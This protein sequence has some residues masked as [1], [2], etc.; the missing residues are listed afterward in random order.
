MRMWV[1][2]TQPDRRTSL[3]ESVHSACPVDTGLG[4]GMCLT[5]WRVGLAAHAHIG[6]RMRIVVAESGNHV[7]HLPVIN[8]LHTAAVRLGIEGYSARRSV[9]V[10]SRVL[11]R[12]RSGSQPEPSL[13]LLDLYESG[14]AETAR[15]NAP[16]VLHVTRTRHPLHIKPID[17]SEVDSTIV[18]TRDGDAV[19]A[20]SSTASQDIGADVVS[21][22]TDASSF[23]DPC[24][25]RDELVRFTDTR[26]EVLPAPPM[27]VLFRR[28]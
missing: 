5:A 24:E 12:L 3:P 7:E 17:L 22:V 9:S 23:S 10:L 1:G 20:L 4:W 21:S 19:L 15:L 2:M 27:A 18:T 11:G 28:A 8:Q 6:N 13:V 16:P 26:V 14:Y 25:F